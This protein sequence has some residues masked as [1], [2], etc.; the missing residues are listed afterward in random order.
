MLRAMISLPQTELDFQCRNFHPKPTGSPPRVRLISGTK[1]S[2]PTAQ[3]WPH[4]E[5]TARSVQEW[6]AFI[7]NCET[8]QSYNR[9]CFI[10]RGPTVLRR[11]GAAI[12]PICVE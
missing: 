2:G 1:R 11:R 6:G 7:A 9:S 10:L 8:V 4:H 5:G 12:L 3:D